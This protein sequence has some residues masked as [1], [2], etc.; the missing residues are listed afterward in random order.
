MHTSIHGVIASSRSSAV[1]AGWAVVGNTFTLAGG[2]GSTASGMSTTRI[3]YVD[4]T[5]DSIRAYDFD[6]TDWTQTGNSLAITVTGTGAIKLATLSSSRVVF[7]DSSAG[8]WTTYDFDGTDWTQ[9]GNTANLN[10]EVGIN[11]GV[12]ALNSTDIAIAATWSPFAPEI[13][14]FRFDGTDWA[15]IG[16]GTI[17]NLTWWTMAGLN[18]TDIVLDSHDGD[19]FINYRWTVGSPGTWAEYGNR[20]DLT[21]A[22]LPALATMHSTRVAY[23]DPTNDELRTYDFDGATWTNAGGAITYSTV[24]RITLASLDTDKIVLVNANA[25]TTYQ[26]N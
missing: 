16:A 5:T 4:Y 7:V 19:E 15:E 18:S 17:P 1:A 26:Y 10:S 12:A 3:A 24:N 25:I 8:K 20:L 22:S 2:G 14:T 21:G 23:F 11:P 9:T 6:G 13:R